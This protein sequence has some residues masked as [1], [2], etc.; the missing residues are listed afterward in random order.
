MV[1]ESTISIE[2]SRF[3]SESHVESYAIQEGPIAVIM[4]QEMPS[5][6]ERRLNEHKSQKRKALTLIAIVLIYIISNIPR[7]LLNFYE[8]YHSEMKSWPKWLH[9]LTSVS[10]LLLVF[11]SSVN[12]LIY[13][14]NKF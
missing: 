8:S 10:H 13:K 7:H 12:F 14:I 6:I 11:N 9:F 2:I 5:R 3:E 1:R 4:E